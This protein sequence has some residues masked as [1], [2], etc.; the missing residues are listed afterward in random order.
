M[1]IID[2]GGAVVALGLTGVLIWASVS[3][4]RERKIPNRAVI[5]VLVLFLPWAALHPIAW[6]LWAVGSAAIALAATFVLY[7]LN[8]VGAGDSKLFAAVAL[9]VGLSQL[10]LLAVFTALAGGLVAAVSLVTRPYRA[11]TMI[12]LR[13][14]GDFGRGVPYGVAISAAAA[15]IIWAKLLHAP[16][17]G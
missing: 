17:P 6:D 16:L 11:M 15:I 9:F 12:T 3:D 4:I 8:I 7:A 13:G 2:P 14:K 1:P 5:A 10:G